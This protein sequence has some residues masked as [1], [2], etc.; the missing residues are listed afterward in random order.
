MSQPHWIGVDL[1]GTKILAGLF[2]D[3]M[4]LVGRAKEATPPPEA[5]PSA[6]FEKIDKAV[7]KVLAESGV[8]ADDVNGLGFGVPGQIKPGTLTVKFAPN[9]D[10]R[11]VDLSAHIP[12][13]WTW[14]T[15]IDNDVRIGTFG[16]WRHGAAKGARHVLGI[17]A[18]TGVGGALILD[19][20]PYY[21]FNY[22]AGE[23]GHVVVHWR[24]GKT[25]EDV[26]GRRSMMRYAAGL[27]ADAPKRVRKEWKGVDLESVK[28][29]QLAEFF[30][31]DD[32]IAVQLV[33]AA[34]KALGATIGG[35]INLLSP[36]VVVLGGGVAGALG[37][38]FRERI[39]EIATRY[40][41][42]GAADGIKFVAAKLEDDSGI[43]GAAA[44]AKE[45]A[46]SRPNRR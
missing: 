9:L 42:P 12:K 40:T 10:W 17:F 27:L 31:K 2:D 23:I 24:K 26:A 30:E 41:L 29:S 46:A 3:D 5:G 6:V 8:K 32:P 16:E 44:F 33:D 18:G 45:Q 4:K 28:S 35:L 22:N 7:V 20:K 15:F 39:W 14:P 25:L 11:D 37:E 19:G 36:E 43:V 21:G 38:G 13:A 1:G 34:A